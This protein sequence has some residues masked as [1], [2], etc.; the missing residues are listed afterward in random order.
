MDWIPSVNVP[1]SI[2]RISSICSP[3]PASMSICSEPELLKQYTNFGTQTDEVR[4][5]TCY[6]YEEVIK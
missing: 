1:G 6:I 2:Q 3:E 5:N 4:Y